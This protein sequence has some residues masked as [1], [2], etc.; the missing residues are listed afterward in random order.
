[1]NIFDDEHDGK[2]MRYLNR[3]EVIEACAAIDVVAV[4]REALK[5]HEQG[6]TVLPAEAYLGWQ[7]SNGFGARSLAMQGMLT[8]A[9]RTAIGLKV[10]NGSLENVERGLP[11]SQGLTM[12]FDKETARPLVLME[13]AYIS[14]LRTAAVTAAT[15]QALGGPGPQSLALIGCGTLAKAHIKVLESSL[16]TL[17]EIRLHDWNEARAKSLA[18][19]VAAAFGDR[20]EVVVAPDSETCVRGADL[21][22][23]VTTVTEGYIPYAW[24][25]PGAVVA[26]V[27]LDDLLPEVAERAGLL[28]VDDWSLVSEDQHRVFGRL[29]RQGRLLSP[30]GERHPDADPV[31][32]ARRVDATIGAV[33]AGTHPGRTS[34]TDV[35]VSNPFG[36]AILD[37]AVADE[38]HRAAV[39]RG[40]GISLPV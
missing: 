36:M 5:S 16:P 3:A 19:A 38:V 25:K 32:S 31:A 34:S 13:A 33:I 21:V 28:L 14:A 11:R 7:T 6:E 27:S 17:T 24:L 1:M 10:I 37:V 29:Y 18:E 26:H 30:S 12:V 40:L 35:V 20:L 8:G 15:A 2:E 4:V 22:V 39:E 9:N 23:P